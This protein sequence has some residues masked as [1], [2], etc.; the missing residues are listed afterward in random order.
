M[1]HSLTGW[2]RLWDGLN[3]SP[4]PEKDLTQ[5]GK[6]LRQALGRRA[7]SRSAI[8]KE[9]LD[10]VTAAHPDLPRHVEGDRATPTGQEQVM[11]IFSKLTMGVVGSAALQAMCMSWWPVS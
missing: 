10:F 11:F 1:K 6:Q 4:V 5:T 8:G 3:R 9:V 7:G 2:Q